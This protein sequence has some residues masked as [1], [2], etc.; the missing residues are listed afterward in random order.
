MSA[1]IRKMKAAAVKI[2]NF[3]TQKDLCTG[4]TSS[5]KTIW[6]RFSFSKVSP[7]LHFNEQQCYV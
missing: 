4:K 2:E 1:K 6:C 3:Y 7:D 5:S